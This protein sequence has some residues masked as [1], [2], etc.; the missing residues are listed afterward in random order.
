MLSRFIRMTGPSLQI[1]NAF[2]KPASD[3]EKRSVQN[4]DKRQ[5]RYGRRAPVRNA[6]QRPVSRKAV[7][8]CGV[9]LPQ[10]PT[11][12]LRPSFTFLKL[13]GSE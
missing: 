4:P 9:V 6:Q 7:Q 10:S 3:M 12:V 8:V 5:W 13:Q 11:S 2:P 1:T